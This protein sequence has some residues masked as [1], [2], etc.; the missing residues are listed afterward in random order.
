MEEF[1]PNLMLEAQ[2]AYNLYREKFF[3]DGG[4]E[5][6]YIYRNGVQPPP[7]VVYNDNF[8]RWRESD[9]P[10]RG[11]EW[12][13]RNKQLKR[14]FRGIVGSMRGLRRAQHAAAERTYAPGRPGYVETMHDIAAMGDIPLTDFETAQHTYAES[15]L[16]DDKWL[17]GGNKSRKSKSRKSKSRKSKSRKSKTRKSKSRKC[18]SRSSTRHRKR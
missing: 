18:K 7:D 11:Q 14:R 6:L 15:D 10:G 17:G 8:R 5:P 16:S 3:A 12:L 1:P 13:L 9:L 2:K 4:V